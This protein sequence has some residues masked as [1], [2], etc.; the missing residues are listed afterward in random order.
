MNIYGILSATIV[1]NYSVCLEMSLS[2]V[3]LSDQN[4]HYLFLLACSKAHHAIDQDSLV[5][6]EDSLVT[7]E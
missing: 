1:T 5:T 6:A 4:P 7:T 3:V 2:E